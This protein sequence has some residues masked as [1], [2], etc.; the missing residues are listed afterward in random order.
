M[1]ISD[2]VD[3]LWESSQRGIHDPDELRGQLSMDDAYAVQL[4]LLARLEESG[5]RLVGWK[6]GLTAK[7]IQAQLGFH[8]PVLG[9]LT[10]RARYVSGSNLDFDNLIAPGF[11]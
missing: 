7:A 5:D 2:A 8:E 6:V 11:E 1:N 4:G 10:E 3:I 9:F